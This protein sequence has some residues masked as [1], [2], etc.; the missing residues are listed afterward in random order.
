MQVRKKILFLVL[1]ATTLLAACGGSKGK[2]PT[3]S[4]LSTEPPA[5]VTTTA[6]SKPAA[7]A[8]TI[9]IRFAI[10]DWEQDR[11]AALIKTFEADN[12]GLEIK[13]VSIGDILDL[14]SEFAWPDDA[15]VRLASSADV[16]KLPRWEE[17]EPGLARDLTP[18]IEADSAFDLDDFYPG[19]LAGC[20]RDGGIWCLPTVA[21]LHLVAF[22]KN[23]FDQAGVPYPEP[24]WTWDDF[25]DKAAALTERQGDEVARWGFVLRSLHIP[26][27]ENLVRPLIDTTADPPTPRFDRPE[28]IEA[29]RWY[30]DLYLEHRVTPYLKPE[31]AMQREALVDGGQA[32]MWNEGYFDWPWRNQQRNVGVVP[33]PGDTRVWAGDKVAMSAGTAHPEAAWRW[34]KALGQG[35]SETYGQKWLPAR[36]SV[37][38]SAGG[39]WDA[40]DD[41]LAVALRYAVDH[42]YGARWSAYH[43]GYQEAPGYSAFSDAIETILS[44]EKS[45]EDAL[46]EAQAQAKAALLKEAARQAEATPVPTV[47]VAPPKDETPSRPGAVTIIFSSSAFS[48]I[49]PNSL[50][51][52][53]ELAKEFQKTHPDIIVEVELPHARSGATMKDIAAGADC[54]SWM[55]RFQ[56]SGSLEAI[57]NLDPFLEAD[58]SF[59]TD[60]FY[61]SLLEPFIWQGQLWGLPSQA[62]PEVILYNRDLFDAAGVDYPAL[63]WTTDDFL[64]T[65]IA[66]THGEG[67]EKQYGFIGGPFEYPGLMLMLERRGARLID[68]SLDPP[69]MAFTDPSTVEALRWYTDFSREYGVKPVFDTDA[70]ELTA[71]FST[72]Y[73]QWSEL[74]YSGRAA[75]WTILES[76]E[77]V[78]DH[79]GM[80]VGLA[81]MPAGADGVTGAYQNVSGYF[82][83]AHTQ[84]GQ[85]CW[86][87][88][89]FLTGQPEAVWGVPARRS[90]VQ[91]E[92]YRRLVGE[93]QAAVYEASVAGADRAPSFHFIA[94]QPWWGISL[95]WLALAHEQV[96]AGKATVEEALA[97]AQQTFDDYR[98]CIIACDATFDKEGQKACMEKVDPT[99]ANL[100]GQ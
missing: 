45:V 63:D 99:L 9:T 92:A 69:T 2:T 17:A 33:F 26:F 11:Y 56:E 40:A 95:F 4:P 65:A 73:M 78:S 10:Y 60:D 18:L 58:P 89:T 51:S 84:A 29:V 79:G 24:G 38:E 100:L 96:V 50:Q 28:V 27:I 62:Q 42:S 80:N 48:G 34:L 30:A 77:L 90:V 47:V 39:F 87:W 32:A 94:D 93:E 16:I 37:A 3:P 46:T 12:P 64:A 5:Q 70:D 7:P 20:Q 54:F 43:R 36:R 59:S 53:R 91:S 22:D 86:E 83:S 74:V 68:D 1:I 23:A 14:S 55:P 66:L 8:E 25:L 98:A 15:W 75:M 72:A 67:K 52:Y 76:L 88:L 61:P 19:T 82:I 81:T 31:E 35:V 49:T 6:E 57:L 71:A 44:G 21:D 41:E 97:A 13:L 85:A